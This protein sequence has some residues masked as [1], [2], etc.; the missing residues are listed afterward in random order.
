MLKADAVEAEIG[1]LGRL[2]HDGDGVNC[3]I[4]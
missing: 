2:S 1:L 4:L 3:L